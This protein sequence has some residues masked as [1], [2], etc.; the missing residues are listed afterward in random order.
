M[1]RPGEA[2][3]LSEGAGVGLED[4]VIRSREHTEVL[5]YS[6]RECSSSRTR[7]DVMS[8]LVFARVR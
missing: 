3:R 7:L 2:G 8:S 1:A 5:V 6:F 4:V